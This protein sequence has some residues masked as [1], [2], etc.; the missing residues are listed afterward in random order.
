MPDAAFSGNGEATME[1][2]VGGYDRIARF[3]VGPLLILVGA[4]SSAGLFTLGAG[5]LGAAAAVVVMF[6]G[7]V[8]TVTAVTQR[9]PLNSMLGFDTAR[10]RPSSD[11]SADD[12]ERDT[13][14]S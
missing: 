2:N 8:L 5:T 3:V 4:A 6:V 12:T 7:A 10:E 14:P 13:R 11:S 9:C 1:K